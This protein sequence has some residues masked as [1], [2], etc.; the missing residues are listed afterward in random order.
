LR[1]ESQEKRNFWLKRLGETYDDPIR[2]LYGLYRAGELL[3]GMLIY[4]FTMNF[5]GAMIPAGGVGLVVVELLHKRQHVAK[6]MIEFFIDHFR[7]REMPIV[8]LYPFRADFYK[9]MGFG[10]GTK[11]SQYRI[12]PESFPKGSS[13]PNVR[14]LGKEDKSAILECYDRYAQ[15]THGMMLGTTWEM[16]FLTNNESLHLVGYE[17]NGDLLGFLSFEFKPYETFMVHD[18]VIRHFIY[19]D[20]EAFKHLSTF[21]HSQRDQVQKINVNTLDDHFHYILADTRDG[22]GQVIPHVYH[23]SNVQGIGL[24]YRIVD[25]RLLFKLVEKG[26][27]GNLAC[28]MKIDLVDSFFP[29]NSGSTIWNFADGKPRLENSDYEVSIKLDV[30]ELSSLLVGSITFKK[31]H[32]YGL[33]QISD[34][35]YLETVNQ[36]FLLE[37]N[38][39]CLTRF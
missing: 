25:L 21:L 7:Q 10:Y 20:V 14:Y 35:R 31:L 36:L 29:N 30:A 26:S 27:F 34:E 15:R 9:R 22:S 8:L 18:L 33:A 28:R 39:I 38:P 11:V 3:G 24:M 4:E 5:R 12:D 32:E 1:I 19:D 16:D 6:E 2:N 23:Q 13:I 37:D 17:E